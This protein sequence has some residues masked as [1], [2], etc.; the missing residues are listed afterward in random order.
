METLISNG[1]VNLNC[2]AYSLRTGHIV[3]PETLKEILN[4]ELRFCDPEKAKNDPMKVVSAFKQISR[5][6]DL[7]VAD[8][9]RQIISASIPKVIE[10]FV[11]H[12]DRIHKLQPLF[13]NINSG[14]IIN[15]F[16]QNGGDELLNKV[17]LSRDKLYVSDKYNSI[18]LNKLEQDTRNKI[19]ALVKQQY[20]KRL[21]VEKIFNEKINSV[22]YESDSVGNIISACLIDNNRIY[23]V[24]AVDSKNIVDLVSDLCKNNYTIW[25]TA[26]VTNRGIIRLAT[27][28]GLKI[29]TD[30][31]IIEKILTSNYPEYKNRIM[32][33]TLG[34]YTVFIKND[35]DDTPQVLLMS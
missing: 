15:L 11:A 34:G 25:A 33:G 13:G 30:P 21:N 1:D 18:E 19:E 14:E 29:I 22:V 12:P 6:P 20:G 4:K 26:I 2:C 28:A 27:Q 10:F 3:N 8:E 23:T 9:T 24:A 31:N 32:T 17:E 35:S 7:L 5:I 16:R